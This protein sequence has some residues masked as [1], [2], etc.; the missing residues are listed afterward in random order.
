M[1]ESCKMS[2]RSACEHLMGHGELP[3]AQKTR[4][5]QEDLSVSHV[6]CRGCQDAAEQNEFS[7]GD[8]FA[9]DIKAAGHLSLGAGRDRVWSIVEAFGE[10]KSGDRQ[11]Q[12]QSWL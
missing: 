8:I 6:L 5:P 12:V 9:F 7:V 11:P 2:V 10:R 1:T 3:L 4:W